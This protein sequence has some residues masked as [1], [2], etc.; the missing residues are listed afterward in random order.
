MFHRLGVSITLVLTLCGIS[1]CKTMR[2]LAA[3]ELA[4]E[5]DRRVTDLETQNSSLVQQVT[6]LVRASKSRDKKISILEDMASTIVSQLE[7]AENEADSIENSIEEL[8]EEIEALSNNPPGPDETAQSRKSK[9]AELTRQ[10]D[11]Q[12]ARLATTRKM[13]K[14]FQKTV[15]D[16][17]DRL[18]SQ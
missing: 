18:A 9:L 7:H 17:Q 5:I 14:K 8:D 6:E 13:L 4:G 16:T 11:V 10:R 1:G 2:T 3:A 15:E 12:N